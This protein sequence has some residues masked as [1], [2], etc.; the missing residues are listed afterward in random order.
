M[1]YSCSFT[2]DDGV[3]YTSST[4][5]AVHRQTAGRIMVQGESETERIE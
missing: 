2:Q 4:S 3:L 5:S 1:W